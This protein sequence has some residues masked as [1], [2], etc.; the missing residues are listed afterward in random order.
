MGL[1]KYAA[2]NVKM[3]S[4]RAPDIHFVMKMRSKNRVSSSSTI[5]FFFQKSKWGLK[6]NEKPGTGI[7]SL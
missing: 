7:H 5:Q 4:R 1:F 6:D 2:P 3:T